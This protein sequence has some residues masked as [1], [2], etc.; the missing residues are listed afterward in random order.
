MRKWLE[1]VRD[2]NLIGYHQ[3]RLENQ[4]TPLSGQMYRLEKSRLKNLMVDSAVFLPWTKPATWREEVEAVLQAYPDAKWRKSFGEG[5]PARAWRLT[6]RPIPGEDELSCVL[7]DLEAG[8][9]VSISQYG[10]ISHSLKCEISVEGHL[11]PLP[12]LRLPQQAYLIDLVYQVPAKA[13][14]W[15]ALPKAFIIEPEVSVRTYP[16]HP[17]MYAGNG[18]SWACPL[19]PQDKGWKWER[20][21]TVSYLD[22]VAIWLLKT[23]VWAR[24][25]AGIAGLGI[26]IGSDTSHDP[27]SLMSTVRPDDPCWCGRGIRYEKCHFQGDVEQAI[28][29]GL[30]NPI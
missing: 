6:M 12:N 28:A 9:V 13:A 17:H 21:A 1:K 16:N 18:S 25:G 14:A 23:A 10:E 30:R 22:Q 11:C 4:M 24:T 7:A 8:R 19:S 5:G 29:R 15:S 26:W 20:G 2:I 3:C 27:A